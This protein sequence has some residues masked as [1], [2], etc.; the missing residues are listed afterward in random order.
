MAH[1][2]KIPGC[3][4]DDHE[5]DVRPLVAD[6]F[7]KEQA[8]R[9]VK[10]AIREAVEG[11]EIF[12]LTNGEGGER[13]GAIVPAEVAN[14]FVAMAP[15]AR[16]LA[17]GQWEEAPDCRLSGVGSHEANGIIVRP[18]LSLPH[19]HWCGDLQQ[20]DRAFLDALAS[21]R[22]KAAVRT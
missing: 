14:A 18:V 12:W 17:G 15:G 5:I 22:R 3:K 21:E 16:R 11:E 10:E 2:C 20:G 7:G 4:I 19:A 6:E 9:L 1:D 8:A 13:V